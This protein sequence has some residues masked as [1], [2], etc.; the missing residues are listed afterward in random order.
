[1]IL[2]LSLHLAAA[3]FPGAELFPREGTTMEIIAV[4][5]SASML[6]DVNRR[7]FYA[8]VTLFG[9]TLWVQWW[10]RPIAGRPRMLTCGARKG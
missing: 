4:H 9:R 5:V 7:S 1:V 6:T 3:G 8:R 10:P 2:A